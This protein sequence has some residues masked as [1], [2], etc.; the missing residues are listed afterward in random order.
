[1]AELQMAP[2]ILIDA[3]SLVRNPFIAISH[4]DGELRG[5]LYLAG[6]SGF[7]VSLESVAEE[8]AIFDEIHEQ[9]VD[10]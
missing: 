8:A 4:T 10:L 6:K 7:N 3:W 5:A 1:M 9:E 2:R